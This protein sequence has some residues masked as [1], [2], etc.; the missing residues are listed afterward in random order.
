[1]VK[2]SRELKESLVAKI[3]NEPKQ[4]I[5][6]VALESGVGISSLH[7]WVQKAKEGVGSKK[8]LMDETI[9]RCP[10]EWSSAQ[11]LEA[12][13]ES[14][15]LSE[16]ELHHYCRR[17]GIYKSQLDQWKQDIMSVKEPS[18]S[19]KKL[20][21]ELKALRDENKQLQRELNRKEKALVEASALLLLKKK[22]D[23]IWPVNE[24]D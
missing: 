21:S 6:S 12:V 15:S 1:M 23:L 17:Q 24:D 5:R 16:E 20:T 10:Q 3:L 8:S 7:G 4:S 2:F 18:D 11:R 14:G 19:V 22:A 13:I 9:D